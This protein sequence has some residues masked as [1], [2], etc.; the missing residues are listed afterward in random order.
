MNTKELYLERLNKYGSIV[1]KLNKLSER[2]STARLVTF[3]AGF[4][5][6]ILAF[7]YLNSLY[8][9]I[10]LLV[11]LVLFI[12]MV[13]KHQKVIDEAARYSNLVEINRRCILRTDGSWM[14][15]KDGGQKYIN[16][17]H[18]YSGD[19]DIFGHASLFKW[20]NTANTYYGNEALRHLLEGPEK[21]LEKIKRRQ[22]AVKELAEKIDFCQNVQC[23]GMIVPDVLNDPEELLKFAE[24]K[25]KL[26]G[27]KL[28]AQIFYIMPELTML[29]IVICFF[30]RTVSAYIPLFLL[31]VQLIINIIGFGKTKT[32]LV[33]VNNYKKRIK[34]YQKMLEVIENQDFKDE[35]LTELKSRLFSKGKPSSSQIKSLE[36][37]AEAID[38]GDG[39]V[40]ALILN[41]LV[42]WN[43]H[44]VFALENW[45]EK[46]GT[47]I[48]TWL[49][50][51]GMFEALSSLALISQMNPDWAFPAFTNKKVSIAAERMGHPLIH[52]NKRI[53]NSVEID[54]RICVVTGSNM[55][56]KTTL[57]RTIGIN[58]VLAYAGT[59]VCAGKFECSIM[60][61]YT[62]MRVS[63][64]L[65]GGISTFYAEL[66]RIKK[67]IEYSK[68]REPMIFLIDEVFRGTN[69]RD[70]VIGARNVVLN[71][72]RDWIMGLISTHD[73]EL[74]ELE[75]GK[76]SRIVNYHF[77]ETYDKD[78]IKFDYVLRH[79][80]C[81][82][83]N[84]RYLMKMVGID[85][86]D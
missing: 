53:S 22:G 75:K 57:L 38:L 31:M 11:S 67:I 58:L 76:D 83:T 49:N 77:T 20:I 80:R 62:S 9:F 34:A 29:S 51:V 32:I 13:V 28:T 73:F 24:D 81:S 21:E 33:T 54:N 84:A 35:Y 63:D 69:S 16:P 4:L 82:T 44:C 72:D 12:Y 78:E 74:C 2:L 23:E 86:M 61:I 8:G 14:D 41:L 55:S 5:A 26:F 56:G 40:V 46:S 6:T 3:I 10:T 59:A 64:D 39:S 1:E 68:K 25:S 70:R 30:D 37:I 48:R 71:L 50:T 19:L 17:E 47:S 7:V 42:F 36:K 43:F 27:R 15:F 85:I 18:P 45:R 60:D 65:S 52:E 79:G 66:L